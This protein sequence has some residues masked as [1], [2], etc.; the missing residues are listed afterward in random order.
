M[1]TPIKKLIDCK[2]VAAILGVAEQT[3]AVWR[4]Q[5]RYP[6]LPWVK[7]GSKVFYEEEQIVLFIQNRM[8]QS[9]HQMPNK[10]KSFVTK[11]ERRDRYFG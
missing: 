3:L 5:Q 9:T 2:Q 1:E 10:A 7:V 6:S 8:R 11:K 4:C